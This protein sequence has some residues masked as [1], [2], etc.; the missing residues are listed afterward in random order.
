MARYEL[1]VLLFLKNC[2]NVVQIFEYIISESNILAQIFASGVI[3]RSF[4]FIYFFLDGGPQP[5]IDNSSGPM[6]YVEHH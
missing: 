1:V 3:P 6:K 5:N 2:E 4:F